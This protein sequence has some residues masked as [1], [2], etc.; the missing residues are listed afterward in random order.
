MRAPLRPALPVALRSALRAALVVAAA[1][2]PV[3]VIVTACAP[4][5]GEGEGEGEG[6][7]DACPIDGEGV[8]TLGEA[9]TFNADCARDL[10]CECV[11]GNCACQAGT[12]GCGASG[13]DGCNDGNDCVTALCV[14]GSGG[15]FV[16][17]GPCVDD[18]DCGAALPVCADI[19]FVGRICIRES[20]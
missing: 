12:R 7:G 13:V 17:S 19:A 8:L 5:T 15:A 2:A 20:P 10:R 18:D 3:A 1:S 14:E 11:D 4:P 16:C 6:E 9:C